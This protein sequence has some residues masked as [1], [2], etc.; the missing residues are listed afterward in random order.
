[1]VDHVRDSVAGDVDDR[2][3]MVAQFAT[4]TVATWGA[5]ATESRTVC[6]DVWVT[7]GV[8]VRNA[9]GVEDRVDRVVDG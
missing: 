3:Q 8:T 4:V 7:N 6:D 9:D 2:S 1:M 5:V